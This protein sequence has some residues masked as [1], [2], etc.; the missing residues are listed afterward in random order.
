MYKIDTKYKKFLICPICHISLIEFKCSKCKI[1]FFDKKFNI[2]S[3]VVSKMYKNQS[4]LN[5]VNEVMNFWG[6]GWAQ[7]LNEEDHDFLYKFNKNELLNYGNNLINSFENKG[8]TLFRHLKKES[9]Q[10]KLVLNIGSGS[11]VEALLIS[12]LS[13]LKCTCIATDITLQ[14]S[15]A[16]HKILKKITKTS[17]GLHADAR[18][19]PLKT[20]SVDVVFSSGVLHHSKDI[21]KSISEIYRVL[22]PNGKA[23]IMLYAKW[24]LMFLQEKFFRNSGEKDWETKNRKNPLTNTFSKNDIKNMFS[25]FSDLYVSKDNGSI[26]QLLKIGKYF[27]KFFDKLIDKYLGANMNII[28]KK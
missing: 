17:F 1:S 8:W 6:N 24:S 19:I 7:R 13:S 12:M 3:F 2:P 4:D 15:L 21:K 18:Y 14:A 5:F 23:Y 25:K 20:N 10:N 16:S 28:V 9:F 27:P 11:G 26:S 22:K